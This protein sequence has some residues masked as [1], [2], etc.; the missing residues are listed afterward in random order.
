MAVTLVSVVFSAQAYMAFD[1]VMNALLLDSL[2][3]ANVPLFLLNSTSVE[4]IVNAFI[5]VFPSVLD[6]NGPIGTVTAVPARSQ[7]VIAIAI[8]LD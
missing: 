2:F 3:A 8:L 1:P 6:W 5:S 4:R 7:P